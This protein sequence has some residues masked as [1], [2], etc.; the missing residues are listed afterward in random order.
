MINNNK[1]KIMNNKNL[2]KW[3]SYEQKNRDSYGKC[4][5]D[6]ARQVMK[7]LD[8]TIIDSD[9]NPHDFIIKAM[10]EIN[11]S[12]ISGFMAWAIAKIVIDCHEKGQEFNE[13][14][15]RNCGVSGKEKITINPAIIAIKY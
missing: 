9:F 5:V 7:N 4:C 10:K 2:K 3:K 13:A 12:G 14:W 8:N 15:N 1:I 6:I 11:E